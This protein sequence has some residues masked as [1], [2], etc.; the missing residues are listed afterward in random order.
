MRARLAGFDKGKALLLF[1]SKTIPS[2]AICLA[3][4]AWSPAT[5]GAP[6]PPFQLDQVTAG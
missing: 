3:S 2:R 5:F 4:F 1:F 6:V